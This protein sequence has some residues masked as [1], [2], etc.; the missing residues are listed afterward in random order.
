MSALTKNTSAS[1]DAKRKVFVSDLDEVVATDVRIVQTYLSRHR[2]GRMRMM[3]LAKCNV[4]SIERT[5]TIYVESKKAVIHG[6]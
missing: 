4:D 3:M 2:Y 1:Y 6:A 5:A